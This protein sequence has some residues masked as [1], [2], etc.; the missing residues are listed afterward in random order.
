LLTGAATGN[1]HGGG[2]NQEQTKPVSIHPISQSGRHLLTF[3]G[4][5]N[6][7]ERRTKINSSV[8]MEAISL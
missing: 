8:L 2:A 7:L 6:L 4:S 5:A 1:K 3:G